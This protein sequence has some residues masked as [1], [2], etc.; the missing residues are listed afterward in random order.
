M[1][2]ENYL[3]KDF[4]VKEGKTNNNYYFIENGLAR[5]Y[6]MP[7]GKEVTNWFFKEGNI[8]F[9]MAGVYY[10][11]PSYG[12]IQ[13][14]EDSVVYKVASDKLNTLLETNLELCNF[15]RKMYQKTLFDLEYRYFRL[16]ETPAAER[17]SIFCQ[18]NPSLSNRIGLGHLASYL[19][20][21]QVTLS[22]VRSQKHP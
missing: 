3:K 12:Y 9:S 19:G 15:S 21:S 1:T 22:R 2:K 17:Y 14:L 16:K 7:D 10:N 4:L 13:F 5:F 11:M 20:M 8:A 6:L 18:E